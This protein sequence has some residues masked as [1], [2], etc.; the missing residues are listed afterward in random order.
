VTLSNSRFGSAPF[1]SQLQAVLLDQLELRTF[2]SMSGRAT[3][4]MSSER[5][6]YFAGELP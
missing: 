6:S 4:Q 2:P 5:Y 1:A 3:G